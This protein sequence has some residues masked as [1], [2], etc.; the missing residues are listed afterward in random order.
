MHLFKLKII[1]T[2]DNLTKPECASLKIF[3]G[4]EKF[5]FQ[6]KNQKQNNNNNNNKPDKSRGVVI[7]N[8]H[9]YIHEVETMLTGN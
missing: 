3:K 7:I 4:K 2:H 5:S 1:S 8:K 6:K 9:D